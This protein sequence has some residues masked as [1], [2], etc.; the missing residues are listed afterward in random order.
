M[1]GTRPKFLDSPFFVGDPGN[2]HLKEGAPPDVVAEFTE[3]MAEQQD[4]PQTATVG[5]ILGDLVK[6][7][8]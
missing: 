7:N 5:D 6:Q 8:K 2:W 1:T 4:A 3:F